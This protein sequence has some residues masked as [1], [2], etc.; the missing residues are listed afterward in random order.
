MEF[1]V[2]EVPEIVRFSA[3]FRPNLAQGQLLRLVGRAGGSGGLALH[4]NFPRARVSCVGGR[5]GSVR[6]G[7]MSGQRAFALL[8]RHRR[9]ASIARG[10]GEGMRPQ[11]RRVQET[12]DK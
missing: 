2:R 4:G 11:S 7:T 1:G 6:V 12:F 8:T 10:A 3:V 9:L 5:S